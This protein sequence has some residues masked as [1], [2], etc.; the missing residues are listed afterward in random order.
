MRKFFLQTILLSAFILPT[1]SYAVDFT[2]QVVEGHHIGDSAAIQ[3]FYAERGGSFLWVDSEELTKESKNIIRDIEQSWKHGLNP[4][5]YNFT[6]L[7][8]YAKNGVPKGREG[9]AEIL[10]ADAVIRYAQDLSGMRLTSKNL[11]ELG[12]DTKSWSRGVDGYGLLSIISQ[13]KNRDEFLQK[14]YP[15]DDTY[16]RLSEE[17]VSIV[18]SLA[19]NPDKNPAMIKYPGLLKPGMR[20]PAIIS[21]REKLKAGGK[22]DLYD[23]KLKMDVQDFQLR[24]GLAADGLIGLRSFDAINQTRT[25][26]LIKLIANLERRRWVRRP[27][28]MRYVEVNIPQMQLRAVENNK[29]VLE[30]PVIIGRDKRPTTSFVDE[31]IGVRFN[32]LWYVPDTIKNEDFLPALQKDPNALAKKGI[33]FRVKDNDG[34]MQSVESTNI[35]WAKITPETVKNIQMYQDSGDDNALGVIRVLMPNQYD[36]YLHD[37]NAP[38]LFKKD[39]RALSSG[40]VRVAEPTQIANFILGQNQGW[41]DKKIGT[42]LESHK[43]KEVRAEK[44]LPVY[45]YYFTAWLDQK[46]RVII[47]NDIYGNDAR[48]VETLKFNGKIPFELR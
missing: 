17:L 22:S 8:E 19:K 2:A 40:C 41:N 11:K 23:D 14:L 24:H 21:I 37:T 26:K 43:L 31:I 4:A 1:P 13:E 18:E 44:P 42:L 30:M 10:M 47:A 29:I 36:I 38:E 25:Q 27:L 15:Q 45:L 39:D 28:P 7:N 12:E 9:E 48:L 46:D 3:K 5:N 6:T 32:P 33:L 34:K 35:D 16:K 20:H